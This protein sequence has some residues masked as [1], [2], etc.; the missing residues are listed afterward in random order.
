MVL[1]V[2][3]LDGLELAASGLVV[4]AILESTV[5]RDASVNMVELVTL[6]L[7]SVRVPLV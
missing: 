6:H 4:R 5:F 3:P 1:A 2:V 7:V